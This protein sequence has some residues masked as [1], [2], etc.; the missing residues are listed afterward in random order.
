MH[1]ARLD[2]LPAIIAEIIEVAGAPAAWELC[3]AHG[4]Q[5]VYIPYA[6]SEDHWLAVLVGIEAATKICVHFRAGNAGV[7]ILIPM[8]RQA[9]AQ[10]RLVK[11]LED[12]MSASKAASVAGVHE[13]TA[14]RARRKL[15][16]DNDDQGNLF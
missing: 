12:G 2:G 9:K 11:A 7:Q 16:S 4:G 13:R 5:S 1:D 6:A 14:Y 15:R 10:Q 8:A 3:R